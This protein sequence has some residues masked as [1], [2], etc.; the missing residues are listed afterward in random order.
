MDSSFTPSDL[1]EKSQNV[2]ICSVEKI[3]RHL[4]LKDGLIHIQFI[5]GSDRRIYFIECMRR[6]IGD[7]FGQKICH[8]YNYDFYDNYLRPYI[9]MS[10]MPLKRNSIPK[11]IYRDVL[12]F[13]NEYQIE[14][15]SFDLNIHPLEL[16]PLSKSGDVIE[17]YPNGK[18]AI[19]FYTKDKGS[20]ID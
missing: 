14:S 8:A 16:I 9:G 1:S 2:V 13:N 3:A 11:K 12:G 10:V 18:S 20:S 17:G 5:V 19:L 15:I 6:L 7:F 4:E